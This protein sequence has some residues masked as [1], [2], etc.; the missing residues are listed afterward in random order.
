MPFAALRPT[1]RPTLR[2]ALCRLCA[3]VLLPALTL[4]SGLA[5]PHPALAQGQ[6]AARP[7]RLGIYH[8]LPRFCA[9][10]FSQR[11][12]RV[13]RF[14]FAL[15]EA[16]GQRL[17]APWFYRRVA[18]AG[19]EAWILALDTDALWGFPP[20]ALRGD[21]GQPPAADALAPWR[22]SLTRALPGLRPDER[23]SG[24]VLRLE[25]DGA[26]PFALSL[27]RARALLPR[28]DLRAAVVAD[29]CVQWPSTADVRQETLGYEVRA[30]SLRGR[31][32]Y[33]LRA[34]V[35]RRAMWN[36]LRRGRVEAL[37]L[38][39]GDGAPADMQAAAGT[40]RWGAQPGTQQVVLRLSPATAE[41]LGHA[42]RGALSRAVDRAGLASLGGLHDLVPAAGFLH[43]LGVAAP[44]EQ[45][46]LG[47]N[48]LDAR[49]QWLGTPGL[50]E[51]L[52]VTV[53]EHPRLNGLAS[54]LASQ[55]RRTLNLQVSLRVL[56]LDNFAV[57][58]QEGGYELLLDVVDLED[59]SLQGLWRQSLEAAGVAAGPHKDGAAAG[60]FQRWEQALQ[61]QLPYLPLLVNEHHLVAAGPR[62]EEILR[63]MCPGCE[64]RR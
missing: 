30:A 45:G 58:L 47:W 43:N 60:G 13:I 50:P 31:P 8:P 19:G 4:A 25:D 1:A 61:A 9:T 12:L 63:V 54:R 24:T 22:Q 38:E 39:A 11:D 56:S 20:A 36:D 27:L 23:G 7:V 26:V 55:W 21:G 33:V 59:G 44:P 32:P 35:E 3:G 52:S 34:Y 10:E 51:R 5:S 2:A 62:A 49:R 16:P 28:F 15:D 18:D 14:V 41:L 42:G 64:A 29:R 17:E 48:T 46:P 37:L 53:L 40:W 6:N 57:A